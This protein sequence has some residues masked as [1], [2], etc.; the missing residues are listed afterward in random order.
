MQFIGLKDK[1][2]KEIYEG[3]ILEL[4]DKLKISDKIEIVEY[5]DGRFL[6]FGT[7][8]DVCPEDYLI[9][10]NIYENPELHSLGI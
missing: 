8:A 2:R 1:N 5:D 7:W 9:V 10:G 6:P 4:I 3:D